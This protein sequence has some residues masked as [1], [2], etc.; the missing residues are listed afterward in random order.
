[1]VVLLA[2]KAL[3]RN[4]D[5]LICLL[6]VLREDCDAV[7]HADGHFKLERPEHLGKNGFNAAAEG[8]SLLR[9]RLQQEQ[10]NSSPPIRKA[11]SEVRSAFLSVAAAA[12]NTSSPRGWPC[13][14]FTSLKR[15]RS[16]ITRLSGCVYRRAR[17][18]SFSKD[19]P[20]SLRL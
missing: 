3:V 18:N 2:V 11:E 12:R 20:K 1:M 6:R 7:V 13:L 14:S 16:R 17:F 9:I 4:P 8:K 5:E 19:S 10:S 15:C